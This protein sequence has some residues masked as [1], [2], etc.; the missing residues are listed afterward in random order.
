MCV[1]RNYYSFERVG[2]ART[3][4]MCVN[5][6]MV[7]SPP[8]IVNVP[9]ERSEGDCNLTSLLDLPNPDVVMTPSP[10]VSSHRLDALVVADDAGMKIWS[11]LGRTSNEPRLKL[12]PEETAWLVCMTGSA[13]DFWTSFSRKKGRT[14]L[15][16]RFR[17][18]ILECGHREEALLS[19]NSSLETEVSHLT[20]SLQE[21]VDLERQRVESVMSTRFGDFVEK[22][23]HIPAEKLAENE[24]AILVQSAT[25][26][27]MD[28]HELN[29]SDLPSFSVDVEGQPEE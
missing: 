22:G 23:I 13:G 5:F 28:V 17:G 9:T 24:H 2:K 7:R 27:E 19:Q 12:S 8:P 15:V 26:D 4:R 18:E 3:L 21:L 25:L 6:L 11:F 16:D 14:L 10:L 1:R 29:L 20:E